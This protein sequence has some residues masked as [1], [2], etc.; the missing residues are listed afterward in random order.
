MFDQTAAALEATVPDGWEFQVTVP[1]DYPTIGD[2]WNA[3]VADLDSDYVFLA[4]DDATPHAG[5]A[6]IARQTADA[7]FIPAPRMLFGDGS[8]ESCGSMGFGQLLGEAPDCTPC[9][10]TGIIFMRREWWDEVGPL[11]P[12]HYGVDD[13]WCW[14]AACHGHTVLYR[15]GMVFTHHHDPT[16][17]LHVRQ[18][19]A[20]HHQVVLDHATHVELPG[21]AVAALRGSVCA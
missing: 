8:L 17:T 12:I 4:I 21:S 15:S 7:G 13:D 18:A 6:E 11:L 16:A 9:R 19:A 3:G 5:W 10:N 1:E 2:A 14:R 20:E